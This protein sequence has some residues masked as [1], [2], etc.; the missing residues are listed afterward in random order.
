MTDISL[1][2]S[3]KKPTLEGVNRTESTIVAT[4]VT[5]KSGL[6]RHP[7]AQSGLHL[8]DSLRAMLV[9]AGATEQ[10]QQSS[11]HWNN[12]HS[13]PARHVMAKARYQ[14]FPVIRR[15]VRYSSVRTPIPPRYAASHTAA[16]VPQRA[17]TRIYSLVDCIYQRVTHMYD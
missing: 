2:Q 16:A 9:S 4:A 1:G 6:L 12:L 14:R 17:Y 15:I 3:G 11:P 8:S 7:S 10:V 5:N 13:I